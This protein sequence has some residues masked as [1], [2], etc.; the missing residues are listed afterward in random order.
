MGMRL[1]VTKRAPRQRIRQTPSNPALSPDAFK[2]PNQQR[3]EVDARRQRGTTEQRSVEL[4]A[5]LLDKPVEPLR[6]QHRVQTL[7]KW[8]PRR[9][10]QLRVGHPQILLPLSM[11]PPAHRH[12]ERLQTI[13]VDNPTTSSARIWTCTTGCQPAGLTCPRLT[14]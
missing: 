3:T 12:E 10:G 1:C 6:I 9:G 7:I 14:E 2:I 11:L 4:R 13:P 5:Q 8:M